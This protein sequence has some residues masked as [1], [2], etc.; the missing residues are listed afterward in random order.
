[1]DEINEFISAQIVKF[2]EKKLGGAAKHFTVF[3]SYRSDG[4]DIDVEVDASVLVDDAYL[5][6]VVDDAAD[7]GICL[8]DI[9]REKGWPINPNDIGK[10]WRS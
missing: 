2:L 7:L 10:C 3:V 8:A 6:K 5:Q 9:I 1:M 4:V